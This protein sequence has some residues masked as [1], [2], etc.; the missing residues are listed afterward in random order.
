MNK[1]TIKK[2]AAI[3]FAAAVFGGVSGGVFNLVTDYPERNTGNISVTEQNDNTDSVIAGFADSTKEKTEENLS[4][5]IDIA[6]SE[7]IIKTSGNIDVSDIAMEAMPSVVA[8]TTKSVQEY[9][10]SMFGQTYEYETSGSGSG[11][12]IGQKDNELLI[13]TNNHVVEGAD[14]VTVAFADGK[15][16]EAKVKGT[17]SS[18]DIAVIEIDVDSLSEDTAESIKIA[19]LGDSDSI[20]VGEQVVA[21]GNALGYGQSVTTGIVSA[22]DRQNSTNDLPLIQTDAAINPGNSGGALLNMNGEVIGINS[23]KYASTEVEGMGYAI[24]I[25]KVEEI[26]TDLSNRRIRDKIDD[27]EAGYMGVEMVTVDSAMSAYYN[28]PVGA[29]ISKVAEDSPAESAGILAKSVIVK[30]DGI[31]VSSAENLADMLDYYAAGE[32][33]EVVCKVPEGDEYVEKTYTVRL[34]NRNNITSQQDKDEE[35]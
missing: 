20:K 11:I 9:N 1:N 26:I 13:V 21:I 2:G 5:N 7:G 18:Y 10:Y 8:I 33:V 31:S 4:S 14:S 6:Q 3:V 15:A 17:D 32:T 29:Y 25:S 23:S 28:L 22:K 27:S 34:G 12:I 24:P 16:Y 19:K 30:F 35:N